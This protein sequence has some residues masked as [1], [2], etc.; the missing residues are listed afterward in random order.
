MNARSIA[1]NAQRRLNRDFT[2]PNQELSHTP[3]TQEKLKGLVA[4]WLSAMKVMPRTSLSTDALLARQDDVRR[5][6]RQRQSELAIELFWS[7]DQPHGWES[8]RSPGS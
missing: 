2:E 3:A 6:I 4:V 8:H 1:F 7:Y 5:A